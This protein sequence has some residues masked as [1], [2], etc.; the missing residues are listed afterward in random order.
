MK[1]QKNP[2]QKALAERRAAA[3][4]ESAPVVNTGL[5]GSPLT[6]RDVQIYVTFVL[7]L[8]VGRLHEADNAM[9]R[10]G[11]VIEKVARY[12]RSQVPPSRRTLYRGWL[13]EPRRVRGHVIFAEPG[14]DYRF[15][16][17]T[18]DKNTA[19]FFADPESI[20]STMVVKQRPSVRG[21]VTTYENPDPNLVIWTH[22]WAAMPIG[23]RKVSIV[24]LVERSPSAEYARLLA[25]NIQ[26]QLEVVLKPIP[27]TVKTTLAPILDVDCPP[28]HELNKRYW[29]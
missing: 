17:F 2:W 29:Y 11:A 10:H 26:S 12:F 15:M 6:E 13:V 3:L 7:T 22:E 9:R 19:C 24:S 14:E 28:T 4:G 8:I 21:F 25:A 1:K 18:H 27:S 5:Y 23:D 20:M 16:S